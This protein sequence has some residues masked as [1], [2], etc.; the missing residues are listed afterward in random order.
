MLKR[1]INRLQSR[2]M[3]IIANPTDNSIIFSK[4]LFNHI[5]RTTDSNLTRAFVFRR[6][7]IGD[8]GF[9]FNHGLNP[10]TT[11]LADIQY[12]AQKHC[13]G[14]ESLN[15][16]VNRIFYDY[17]LSADGPRKL[18]VSPEFACGKPY[19]R[20]INPNTP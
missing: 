14:F 11:Q 17:A 9:C 7:P 20:I 16:T 13:I 18:G 3:F 12:N 1:L 4:R 8:Y 19:Y 5:R 10:Q 6:S 15:P 2:K